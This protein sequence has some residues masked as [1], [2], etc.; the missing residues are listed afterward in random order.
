ME[1]ISNLIIIIYR[2][3]AKREPI[4]IS[5][6]PSRPRERRHAMPCYAM[7]YPPVDSQLYGSKEVLQSSMQCRYV[8]APFSL[9]PFI[10]F[11]RHCSYMS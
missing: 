10:K 1:S 3:E 11:R 6:Y 7:S 9:L 5:A 4:Y 8:P 2:K